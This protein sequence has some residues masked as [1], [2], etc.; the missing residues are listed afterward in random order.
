M[1]TPSQTDPRIDQAAVTD[2]GLLAAHEKLLGKQPDE[3]ARYRLLPLNL[4]FIFSALIFFGG[5]YLGR[6]S[7]H[8]DPMVYNENVKRS[9][10]KGVPAPPADPI[11]VG[12]K[13]FN[14][15]ACNTCHQPTG[16]G[17]PGAFPPLVKSDWVTGSEER[18]IRIVLHGIVGPI[19]VN[20]V[21][22]NSA[23]PAFG[24]VAGSGYNWTDD[25]VAAVLTYVRQA[26]GNQAGPISTEKVA[27]IRA[28]EGDRK[29]WTA[30]ELEKLP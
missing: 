2:E 4:L 9:G 25:K 17:I 5:T 24:R 21:D 3:K 16:L 10:G 30:A 20:G 28:K 26:W 14:N 18:V 12:E 27:E 13:L 1:T 7:G 29:P 22:Y 23:M 19:K 15:A 6:Y 8:F 11:A